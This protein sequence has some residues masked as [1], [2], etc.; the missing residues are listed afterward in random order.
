MAAA[1]VTRT[2]GKCIDANFTLKVLLQIVH[3]E[4]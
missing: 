2:G 4:D 1:H 3:L